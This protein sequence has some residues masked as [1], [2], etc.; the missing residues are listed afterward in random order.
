MEKRESVPR[1][2]E[3]LI[4]AL[5]DYEYIRNDKGRNQKLINRGVI[6]V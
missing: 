1:F 6:Y 5:E 2:V 4:Y 3:H